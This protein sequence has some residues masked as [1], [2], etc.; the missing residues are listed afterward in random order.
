MS[1]PA[2]VVGYGRFGRSCH[3]YLVNL[4]PGIHLHG[5]VA[6]KEAVRQQIAK[7]QNCRSY[8]TLEEAL[9]DPGVRLVIIATPNH[10]HADQAVQAM[11]AG[12]HVV[13]DK[14]MCLSLADCERMLAAAE[15]QGVM[16]SVFQNRRFDGDFLTVKKLLDSGTLG[17]VRWI[18]MAWQG[19]GAWGGW[20]GQPESG[21]G[22]YYD[23]GAHLVDQLCLL[24][25]QAIESVY[26][27]MHYDYAERGIESEALLIV[28]FAGGCTGICDLSG[29]NALSKPRFHLHGSDATFEKYGLDPQEDAMIAGDIDRAVNDPEK[30]G[31]LRT[32]ETERRIGTVPGRWRNFYENIAAVINGEAEPVVKPDE[33]R[34][35]VGVLEAGKQSAKTSEVVR[36]ALPALE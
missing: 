19:F 27:R 16:L 14:V 12:K 7:E 31:R 28:T 36:P 32:R 10:L 30:D 25:P 33:L 20:R 2:V 34:R 24:F 13:T 5:V 8:A 23:L 9:A 15:R 26:G 3:S 21:G 18:E 29:L 1:I 6:R 11:E 4:T 17:Q 22:R 35:Q